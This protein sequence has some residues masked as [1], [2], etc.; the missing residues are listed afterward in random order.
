MRFIQIA[1][2]FLFGLLF[3][4]IAVKDPRWYI[5]YILAGAISVVLGIIKIKEK[6]STTVSKDRIFF[7]VMI[8]LVLIV[9]ISNTIISIFG[10][11]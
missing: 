2:D 4:L 9:L 10:A 1:S 6:P 5:L 8:F 11:T 3:F 7:V